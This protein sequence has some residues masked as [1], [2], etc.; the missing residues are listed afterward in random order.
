MNFKILSKNFQNFTNKHN[1][2]TTYTLKENVLTDNLLIIPDQGKVFKGNYIAII[3]EYQFQNAWSD[4]ETVKRFRSEKELEKYLSK[5]YPEF[6][7]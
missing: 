4:K 2:M 5:N 7:F 6:Y 3:K 1:T